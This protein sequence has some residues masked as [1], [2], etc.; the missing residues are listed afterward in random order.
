MGSG[1]D[2]R[3]AGRLL[4]DARGDGPEQRPCHE[5]L[6]AATDDKDV[7]ACCPGNLEQLLGGSPLPCDEDDV[8]QR[9][10]GCDRRLG[11]EQCR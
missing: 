11:G 7:R 5:M 9:R 6:A 10:M 1:D 3:V 8:G 2:E 4:D